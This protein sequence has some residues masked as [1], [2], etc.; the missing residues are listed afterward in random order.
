MSN[1]GN[2]MINEAGITLEDFKL[3]DSS[4]SAMLHTKEKF[5]GHSNY[6]IWYSTDF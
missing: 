3:L 6:R 4:K 2:Y 5:N 1:I